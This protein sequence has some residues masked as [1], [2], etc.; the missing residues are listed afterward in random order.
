MSKIFVETISKFSED[1][2][3]AINRLVGQLV[4][5]K[6]AVTEQE[7]KYMIEN[8]SLFVA[9]DSSDNKIVGMVTLIVYRLPS[10]LRGRLEEIVVDEKCR[11]MGIG[12]QLMEEAIKEARERG[13]EHIDLSSNPKRIG[14]NEFYKKMGFQQRETNSYRLY[15]KNESK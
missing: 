7:I 9:R 12:K 1:L 3:E 5:V 13:V 15:L 11:N 4:S 6:S 8:N 14:A 10:V 2:T